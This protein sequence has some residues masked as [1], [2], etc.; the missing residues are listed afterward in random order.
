M[1]GSIK[2]QHEL[3]LNSVA[4]RYR[5]LWSRS[6]IA[7]DFGE[8]LPDHWRAGVSSRGGPILRATLSSGQGISGQGIS[9]QESRNGVSNT[10]AS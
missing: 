7:W 4:E 3:L 6:A 8:S 10:E 2:A 5:G 9:R 1:S